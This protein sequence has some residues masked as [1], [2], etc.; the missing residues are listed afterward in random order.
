MSW[1]LDAQHLDLGF[2]AKHMMVATVKGRF[3]EVRA[4][5]EIDEERPEISRV[6]AE[7]ATASLATGS[8]DRDAHLKSPDFLDVEQYPSIVFESTSVRRRGDDRFE[9]RGDLTIRDV[10]RSVAFEGEFTGPLASPWGDRRV[11]FS[12]QGEIDREEFG[13]VWNVA[14]ETGGVLVGRKVK[15]HLDAEVVQAASVAA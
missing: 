2:S 6:R 15:L 5:I 8:A 14:L 9:L 7:I 12:L 11:G 3:S 4:E 10:T 13:L 1:T